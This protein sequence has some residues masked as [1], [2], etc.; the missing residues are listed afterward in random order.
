MG[1]PFPRGDLALAVSL[2]LPSGLR[3]VGGG[4]EILRNVSS[5]Q[6]SGLPRVRPLQPFP[7][8]GNRGTGQRRK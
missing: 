7:K 2:L 5:S 3:G 4:G 8:T 6:R 1:K